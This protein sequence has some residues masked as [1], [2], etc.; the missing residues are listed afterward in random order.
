MIHIPNPPDWFQPPRQAEKP[1]PKEKIWSI[2]DGK[3]TQYGIQYQEEV[4][5]WNRKEQE[6]RY[7]QWVKHYLEQLRQIAPE[8]FNENKRHMSI[9]T[10]NPP[11]TWS[12][13]PL[14]P[15]D[16]IDPLNTQTP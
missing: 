2:P 8:L 14:T 9:L 10:E 3:S 5:A 15:S 1:Q 16:M 6:H 13:Y 12:N 11:G 7:W 4:D